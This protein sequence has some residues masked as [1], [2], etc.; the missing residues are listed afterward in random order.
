MA[1]PV[2]EDGAIDA[3]ALAQHAAPVGSNDADERR[4]DGDRIEES[5]AAVHWRPVQVGNYLLCSLVSAWKGGLQVVY[6]GVDT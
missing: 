1:A 2:A 6:I 3:K 5:G 4:S